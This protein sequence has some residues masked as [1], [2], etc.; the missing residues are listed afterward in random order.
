MTTANDILE[1][2]RSLVG[3]PYRHCGRTRDSV[4]CSGMLLVIADELQLPRGEYPLAYSRWPDGSLEGHI[5]KDMVEISLTDLRPGSVGL[6]WM[7]RRNVP[8]H[9][10]IFTERGSVIH[11]D[12][13]EKRVVEVPYERFLQRRL[14]SVFWWKGVDSWQP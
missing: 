1:K 3:T 11:S 4:D 5:R 8:Q 13:R 2:A 12:I 9:V 14:M 7:I 10:A 6:F